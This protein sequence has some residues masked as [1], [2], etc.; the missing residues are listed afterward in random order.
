MKII[1]I[2]ESQFINLELVD[3]IL[4]ENDGI[5]IFFQFDNSSIRLINDDAERFKKYLEKISYFL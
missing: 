1:R 4:I 2:N 5:R 3:Y